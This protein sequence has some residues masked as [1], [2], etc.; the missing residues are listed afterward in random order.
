MVWINHCQHSK[1]STND[2]KDQKIKL[3]F[4]GHAQ[5]SFGSQMIISSYR[6]DIGNSKS[7]STCPMHISWRLSS[8]NSD[9][10]SAH[11]ARVFFYGAHD[12]SAKFERYCVFISKQLMQQLKHRPQNVRIVLHRQVPYV[13]NYNELI[14]T[15]ITT[16][17]FYIGI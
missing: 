15:T 10:P 11:A 1:T 4:F 14:T 2:I 6:H 13:F 8:S 3:C 5:Q 16:T 9:Q 7:A 12:T 17:L